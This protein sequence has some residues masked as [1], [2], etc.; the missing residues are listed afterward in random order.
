MNRSQIKGM[1]VV[2]ELSKEKKSR[3]G[4]DKSSD[5]KSFWKRKKRK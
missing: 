2:V 1:D 3:F 4:R 5:E